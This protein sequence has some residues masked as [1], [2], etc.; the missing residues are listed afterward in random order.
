MRFRQLLSLMA[1]A[2]VSARHTK[3]FSTA[4]PDSPKSN[5]SEVAD[6]ATIQALSRSALST[7]K[8]LADEYYA[9]GKTNCSSDNLRVRREW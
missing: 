3:G 7:S 2:S 5:G 8:S 9:A 6:Y 1:I 4:L